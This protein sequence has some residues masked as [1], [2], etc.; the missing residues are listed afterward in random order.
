MTRS[1][2]RTLV[3][4]RVQEP[5]DTHWTDAEIDAAINLAYQAAQAR[6]LENYP[7]AYIRVDRADL[8]A[9]QHEYAKP[10][11]I[12]SLIE[13]AVKDSVTGL[14]TPIE[15]E[16][17]NVL[18]ERNAGS[19]SVQKFADLGRWWY[20]DPAPSASVVGGLQATIVP[21]L[22]LPADTSVPQL[23]APWHMVLVINTQIILLGETSDAV[24][25]LIVE[26]D[27]LY[28]RLSGI[29]RGNIPETRL[30]PAVTRSY[31]RYYG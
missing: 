29:R 24:E 1:D 21:A 8:V 19:T 11:G 28:T 26:R 5:G 22:S 16:S 10:E 3:K 30:R 14:Y 12:I 4:R 15:S 20:L 9:D 18:R 13:L 25:Q 6:H 2:I 17:F 23:P 27:L 7:E 31:R